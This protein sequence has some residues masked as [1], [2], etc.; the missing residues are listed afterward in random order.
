MTSAAKPVK[1]ARIDRVPAEWRGAVV[2]IGNFDGVHRGHQAV[3]A[4]ARAEAGR[5][6]VACLML[7]L[8]PHPRAFF[9][10]RPLFRLT[11]E[12]LKAACAAAMGLDGTLVLPFDH[13]IAA[14]SA[15]DFV[16]GILVE[17]LAISA[18]ATGHDFQ[19][20]QARRG[21]P[22]FLQEQGVTHGFSVQV[23][24]ALMDGGDAVS[25]TRIRTAL[26][27]GDP[28]VANA[29]LGWRFA[30]AGTVVHGEA[31][32]RKLGYPTANM[33]LDPASEL[34]HGIYAVR[35]RRADGSLHDGVAS[36]GRRP[37]FDNG[38]PLLE[39]FLFDFN[40]DLYGET[41]LVSLAGFIRPE[42][43]FDSIAELVARM[44]Q[45]SLEARA[46]LEQQS[47]SDLDYQIGEA[48][49]GF[50]RSCPMG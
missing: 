21:T 19:F 23:V 48:W 22:E 37:T 35:F 3:L 20:G 18:V 5:R 15:E 40:G 47:R 34:A 46:L 25:S 17:Q 12:P 38:K 27:S 29:L 28:E 9:S 36:Y 31:R 2:A 50:S 49:A 44:D 32:G 33:A 6:G 13:S 26:A 24:G 42:R 43:R 41:A 45:D 10:G 30:V 1:I 8:E 39:T 16:S 11:P 4:A 7:T 14:M